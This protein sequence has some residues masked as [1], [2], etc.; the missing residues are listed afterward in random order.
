MSS[1][2]NLRTHTSMDVVI[3]A[4]LRYIKEKPIYRATPKIKKSYKDYH[5]D[6]L[7]TRKEI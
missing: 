6:P 2:T 5:L 4:L 3:Y 7:R 1:D